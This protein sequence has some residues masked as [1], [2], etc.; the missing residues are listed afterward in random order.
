MQIPQK[1][2]TKLKD[3][4]KVGACPPQPQVRPGPILA[5]KGPKAFSS[6][7]DPRSRQ[8]NAPKQES[9]TA[10]APL[11]AHAQTSFCWTLI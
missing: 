4:H 2:L 10:E 6:E 1:R 8:E 11:L 5:V 3:H 9:G 7:V